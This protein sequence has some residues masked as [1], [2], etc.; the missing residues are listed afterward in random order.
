LIVGKVGQKIDLAF[1]DAGCY[2]KSGC[3]EKKLKHSSCEWLDKQI[4]ETVMNVDSY[5]TLW[6]QDPIG[7]HPLHQD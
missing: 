2:A 1:N 7:H 5:R 6:R 4:N 3:T